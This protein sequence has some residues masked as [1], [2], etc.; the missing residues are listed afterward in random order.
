LRQLEHAHRPTARAS[1]DMTFFR[2]APRI[3]P[4]TG[5]ICVLVA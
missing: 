2:E 3:N 5:V 1:A 4:M